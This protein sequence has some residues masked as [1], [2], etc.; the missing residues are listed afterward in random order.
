M[1]PAQLPETPLPAWRVTPADGPAVRVRAPNWLA[2]LGVAYDFLHRV[3]PVEG[4]AIEEG[5]HGGVRV[6]DVDGGTVWTVHADGLADEEI[7]PHVHEVPMLRA[8]E[9]SGVVDDPDDPW[10]V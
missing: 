3:L 7:A 4:L 6:R 9:L 2:A 1:A 5:P 10:V 8:T